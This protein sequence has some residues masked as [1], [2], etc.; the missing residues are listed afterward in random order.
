[1]KNIKNLEV[2]SVYFNMNKFLKTY[3]KTKEQ[4]IIPSTQI[5]IQNDTDLLV[6]GC[7]NIIDYD[8][9]LIQ[10]KLKNMSIS[11]YGNNLKIVYLNDNKA[12]ISGKI[13]RLEYIK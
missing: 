2:G 8:N 12:L 9:N 10:L 5:T 4:L 11:I 7:K 13:D 1:M 3:L 6:D